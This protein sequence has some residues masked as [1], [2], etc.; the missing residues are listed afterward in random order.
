[1][2]RSAVGLALLILAV[3]LVLAL[4]RTGGPSAALA[5]LPERIVSLSSRAAEGIRVASIRGRSTKEMRVSSPTPMDTIPRYRYR[6][7]K[8]LTICFL[9]FDTPEP[10][11]TPPFERPTVP[12]RL[13]LTPVEVPAG[14]PPYRP[15]WWGFLAGPLLFALLHDG[16]G[17][18]GGVT[19]PPDQ[20]PPGEPPPPPEQVVPEPATMILLG[21][22]I[23]GLAA[24]R[25]RRAQ[26][27]KGDA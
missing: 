13:V 23:V 1:M 3:C 10:G 20:P 2:R 27:E 14:P 9:E 26:R 19:V 15:N 22:G 5:L 11:V 21:T 25:R 6:I 17:S 24:A 12:S 18:E 7:C 16:G 4:G 8:D